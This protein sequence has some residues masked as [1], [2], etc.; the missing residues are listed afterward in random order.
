MGGSLQAEGLRDTLPPSDKSLSKFFCEAPMLPA[1]SLK[2]LES[3]CNPA[4]GSKHELQ[5]SSSDRISQGLSAVWVLILLRPP[6]RSECLE[7][8]LKVALCPGF[9]YETKTICSPAISA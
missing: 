1:A 9:Y 2:L 3:L 7:I 6:M 5:P 8:V 4:V